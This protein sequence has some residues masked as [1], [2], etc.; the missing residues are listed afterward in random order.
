MKKTK[1]TAKFLFACIVLA[2]C[3]QKEQ[4]RMPKQYTI[5]QLRNTV[6]IGATGFSTDESRV[7]VDANGT[8]IYNVYELNIADTAINL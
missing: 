3:N 6:S 5:E 1:T 4:A 7:L 8:G 2:A